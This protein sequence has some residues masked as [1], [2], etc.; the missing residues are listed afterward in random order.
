M[1]P[2]LEHLALNLLHSF[3][4]TDRVELVFTMEPLELDL[5][6][7]IACGLIVNELVSNALRYAFPQQASGCLSIGLQLTKPN[8]VCLLILDDGVGLPP[9]ININQPQTLGLR[10]VQLLTRQLGG[11]LVKMLRQGTAFKLM[12]GC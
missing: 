7:A 6:R 12:F 1:Q 9:E 3:G 10:L 4:A 11:S 5:D 2:Y 8:Q